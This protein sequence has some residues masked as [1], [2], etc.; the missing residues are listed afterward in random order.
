[1][2]TRVVAMTQCS[3]IVVMVT[4][5]GAGTGGYQDKIIKTLSDKFCLSILITTSSSTHAVMI[6]TSAVGLPR[7]EL[8]WNDVPPPLP[9]PPQTGE[10]S[11][12]HRQSVRNLGDRP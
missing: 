3:D 1:M 11:A 6:T 9:A 2:T 7:A 8:R 5:T 12:H 4:G 10:I